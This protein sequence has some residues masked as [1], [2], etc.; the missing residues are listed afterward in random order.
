MAKMT[1]TLV[2]FAIFVLL[3]LSLDYKCRDYDK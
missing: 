3:Y 1:K 2:V